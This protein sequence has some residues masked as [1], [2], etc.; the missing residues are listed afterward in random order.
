[1]VGKPK[2]F[3]ETR[4]EKREGFKFLKPKKYCEKTKLTFNFIYNLKKIF[5]K[6]F[7]KV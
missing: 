6:K 2:L 7:K 1:M 3:I 5:G 4:W